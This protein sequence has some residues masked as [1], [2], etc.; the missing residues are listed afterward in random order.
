MRKPSENGLI[1]IVLFVA[2][3]ILV[4]TVMVLF[5][6]VKSILKPNTGVPGVLSFHQTPFIFS[7]LYTKGIPD[8][9]KGEV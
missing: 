2:L 5:N 7:H 8:I 9:R 6:T 1:L 4:I 3:I